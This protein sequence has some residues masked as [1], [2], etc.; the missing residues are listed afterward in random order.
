VVASCGGD[1]QGSLAMALA[2]YIRQ[3]VVRRGWV[4]LRGLGGE[5]QGAFR[6][7]KLL[8]GARQ[9]VGSPHPQ[10]LHQGG[11]GGIA[12]GDQ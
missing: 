2:S 1:F 3:I 6:I 5:A 11:L 12:G 9:I 4:R 10:S 7:G 8:K